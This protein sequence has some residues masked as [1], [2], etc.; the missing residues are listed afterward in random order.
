MRGP[1][2]PSGDRVVTVAGDA[3]AVF[4]EDE[5]ANAAPARDVTLACFPGSFGTFGPVASGHIGGRSLRGSRP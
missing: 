3:L 2:Q 4:D 1:N 5:L